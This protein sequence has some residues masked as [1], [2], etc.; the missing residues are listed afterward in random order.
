MHGVTVPVGED[1][2]DDAVVTEAIGG[3]DG[4][5]PC[6]RIVDE[7]AHLGGL[8]APGRLVELVGAQSELGD[9]GHLGGT[10]FGQ[11]YLDPQLRPAVEQH[12]RRPP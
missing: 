9:P 1:R 12:P 4:P 2:A 7:G 6:R 11:S 5:H 3:P 10:G 8:Q